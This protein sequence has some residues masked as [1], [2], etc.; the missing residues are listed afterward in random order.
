MMNKITVTLFKSESDCDD[1]GPSEAF[2]AKIKSTLKEVPDIYLGD[3]GCCSIE[4]VYFMDAI[5]YIFKCLNINMPYSNLTLK[6][7][8]KVGCGHPN[9]MYENGELNYKHMIRYLN[10]R[11]KIKDGMTLEQ[12][13]TEFLYN[14]GIELT[15]INEIE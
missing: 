14:H 6:A 15:V 8:E 1:C 11:W 9:E 5:K 2:C 10:P 12:T 7:Q 3:S 13:A 4:N